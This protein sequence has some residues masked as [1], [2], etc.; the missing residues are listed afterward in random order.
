MISIPI[1]LIDDPFTSFGIVIF[2]G[3]VIF[4][5]VRAIGDMIPG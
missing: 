5:I 3:L 1:Y 2:A 4:R